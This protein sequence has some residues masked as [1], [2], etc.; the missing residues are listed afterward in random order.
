MSVYASEKA[1]YLSRALQSIWHDQERKPDQIVLVQDGLLPTQLQDVIS[2]FEK[3]VSGRLLLLKNDVNLGLP[4]SLNKG[5]EYCTG[6][7]VARMDSDDIA[8]PSRFRL[9]EQFMDSHPDIGVIGGSIVEFN[10]S[11]DDLGMRTYPVEPEKIRRYIC[12]ANPLVH[13][14]VMIRRS[15]V[16]DRGLRYSE[17]HRTSQDLA[18]WYECLAQGVKISNLEETVLK[19]RRDDSTLVRRGKMSSRADEVAIYMTGIHKLY[20]PLSWRIIY[21]IARYMFR[22]LPTSLVRNLYSAEFRQR[23]L[24]GKSHV[25]GAA[26]RGEA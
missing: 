19:F 2:E 18:L 25:R 17:K 3:D 21:P 6:D 26:G 24:R 22:M 20:G 4:K 13:S 9:Q 16:F 14:T 12:K 5:I 15:M 10:D 1:S 7:Y 8:M 11:S 23:L